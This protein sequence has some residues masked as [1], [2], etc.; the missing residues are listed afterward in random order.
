MGAMSP[1]PRLGG[2]ARDPTRPRFSARRMMS[3]G[4]CLP[5]RAAPCLTPSSSRCCS[6]GRRSRGAPRSRTNSSRGVQVAVRMP[7]SSL[8]RSAASCSSS[9]PSRW[10]DAL[11]TP[12][13][14]RLH[15]RPSRTC[16]TAAGLRDHAPAELHHARRDG[17][18]DAPERHVARE[19]RPLPAP[20]SATYGVG[21]YTVSI[22]AVRNYI[23]ALIWKGMFNAEFG[24]QRA[25]ARARL[26][27]STGSR[28]SRRRSRPT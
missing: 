5:C 3:C 24:D 25:P 1:Q 10:R 27:P 21:G 16:A 8:Q 6:S 11:A 4:S 26:Q 13:E 23:T 2:R 14:R 28:S 12:R 19:H 7:T 22:A 17:D 20:S 9:C 15:L 18:V